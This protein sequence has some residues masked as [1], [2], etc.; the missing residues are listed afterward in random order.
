MS[1]LQRSVASFAQAGGRIHLVCSQE[2]SER[3]IE[4]IDSGYD[5]RSFITE[6]LT[7]EIERGLSSKGGP[8]AF[9]FIS[10]LIAIEAL[11]IRIAFKPRSQGIFHEK[12]GI[13]HDEHGNAISFTGSINESWMG[14][15]AHG[16]YESF[17]VFNTWG[18]D[19]ER[20][21][22]HIEEF[23]RL[24]SNNDPMLEVIPFPEVAKD[25]LR[26]REL[27]LDPESAFDEFERSFALPQSSFQP[28]KHQVEA[29]LAWEANDHKGVLDHATG[30][31]KTFTAILALQNWVEAFGP[32]L[33]FVPSRLL[34]DQW[35][36]SIR[37]L[38]GLMPVRAGG[39][40]S[41]WRRP[42]LIEDLTSNNPGNRS[43]IIATIQ[44][45]RTEHFRRRVS[46]GSHLLL[47]CDEVHWAGA[48]ANSD[49][50]KIDSGGRLG[51]S[52]T[53]DRYG[54]IEGT[55]KIYDYFGSVIH[56]FTLGDAIVSGRLCNYN[57][58][59]HIVELNTSE[60]EDWLN[61]TERINQALARSRRDSHGRAMV[62]T[63]TERLIFRRARI[64]KSAEAKIA[65]AGD[66]VSEN[67]R[68]GHRWLIY[69][70]D[71][72]Q[73]EMVS[74]EIRSRGI[75]CD[76]YFS[77]MDSDRQATLHKFVSLGG[78][79]VAIRCLDEGVDIPSITHAV[80]LASSKNP[81]EFI[82]RRGRV[83]RSSP[84]KYLA[85]IH[86][87]VVISD[88]RNGS[89][90]RTEHNIV[91]G[92]IA[93]SI[94]FAADSSNPS[95]V[96]SLQRIASEMGILDLATEAES[97]SQENDDFGEE[98]VAEFDNQ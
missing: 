31:G 40:H 81:R 39:G 79:I 30:S 61:L 20:V 28:L 14:W 66:I 97:G 24:W 71:R 46:G 7:A 41:S 57:Y 51:L 33:I 91:R 43:V 84:G 64:V 22:R 94:R 42:G 23:E 53:P 16:N 49:I 44:T 74:N 26:I 19:Q 78:I 47:I 17:E 92:E 59:P 82:Q 1:L 96:I 50:M 80:I 85:H 83:L 12:L 35:F 55:R 87:A 45:G 89:A 90:E 11:D 73:L 6:S 76:E 88:P 77:Y 62:S 15:N 9:D 60:T 38:T 52:A 5:L 21:N 54:D 93:R 29:I 86:D 13:F 27:I 75:Q 4:S 32:V 58:Y 68:T 34:Q 10:S 37:E 3:D 8:Q 25:K 72:S 65:L 95:E 2:L 70:E 36:D 67:Y 98:E 69:C 18:Q 48:D 63:S 56:R